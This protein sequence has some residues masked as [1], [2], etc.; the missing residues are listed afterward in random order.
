MKCWVCLI[1]LVA[2]NVMAADGPGAATEPRKRLLALVLEQIIF[3][4]VNFR[5][6]EPADIIEHVRLAAEKAAST[7]LPPVN[8]VWMVPAETKL[9][10]VTLS[11]KNVPALEV[12][13]YTTMAAGLKYRVEDHAVVIY[14]A[15]PRAPKKPHDSVP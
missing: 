5:D 14:P 13:R 8:V 9:P 2:A 4:E 10:R 6:A 3:A 11:L 1:F 12:L 7:N 15:P